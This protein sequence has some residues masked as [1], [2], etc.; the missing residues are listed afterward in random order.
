MRSLSFHIQGINGLACGHE[1]AIALDPAKAKIGTNLGQED[2]S[3][4]LTFL[5]LENMYSV[6]AMTSPAGA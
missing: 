3:D 5:W 6:K 1:Q 4:A 2:L